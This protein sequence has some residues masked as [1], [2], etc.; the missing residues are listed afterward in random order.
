MTCTARIYP[1][2]HV[3][4]PGCGVDAVVSEA[5]R[6]QDLERQKR[7]AEAEAAPAMSGAEAA[8]LKREIADLLQPGESVTEALKR[9][10]PPPKPAARKGEPLFTPHCPD[11]RKCN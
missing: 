1:G 10:R 3:G 7:V 4:L 5:V 8:A 2:I 11:F 9:L 6:R